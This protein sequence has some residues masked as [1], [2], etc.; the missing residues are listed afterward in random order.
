MASSSSSG[1]EVGM[2]LTGSYGFEVDG[3]DVMRL[4]LQFL[5]EQG[6]PRAARELQVS[7]K[8]CPCC[9]ELEMVL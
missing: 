1:A 6:L 9:V 8:M 3:G 2:M 4:V 5:H 7:P